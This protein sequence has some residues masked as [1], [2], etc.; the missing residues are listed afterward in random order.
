MLSSEELSKQRA[1]ELSAHTA[2]STLPEGTGLCF[3]VP[4]SFKPSACHSVA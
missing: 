2:A 3:R 1:L 4:W